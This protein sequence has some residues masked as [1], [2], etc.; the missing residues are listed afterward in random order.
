MLLD[1]AA[2]ENIVIIP[3][4]LR[5]CDWDVSEKLRSLKNNI[6]PDVEN[7]VNDLIRLEG[8]MD[9]VLSGIAK[10]VKA[11]ALKS[12]LDGLPDPSEAP[13]SKTFYYVLSGLLLLIGGVAAFFTQTRL[14]D[15]LMTTLVFL[16]FLVI[17][18]LAGRNIFFPTKIHKK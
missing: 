5:N 16:L 4:L 12:E 13:K 3:V 8:N 2:R 6:L 7:T 11:I 14:H 1:T 17:I 10:K 9:K 15:W 18:L